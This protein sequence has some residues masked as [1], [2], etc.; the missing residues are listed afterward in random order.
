MVVF[1]DGQPNAASTGAS[2]LRVVGARRLRHDARVL[3]AA[4]SVS[5]GETEQE[6][7]NETEPLETRAMATKA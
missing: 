6:G 1:I 3:S 4:S 2:G 5:A 7:A